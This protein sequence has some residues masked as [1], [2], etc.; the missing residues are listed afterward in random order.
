MLVLKFIFFHFDSGLV[1]KSPLLFCFDTVDSWQPDTGEAT[2]IAATTGTGDEGGPTLAE[3]VLRRRRTTSAPARS[4]ND[5]R[6]ITYM[7]NKVIELEAKLKHDEL[8]LEP[9]KSR[10]VAEFSQCEEFLL[11]EIDLI[12]RHMQGW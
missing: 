5:Q 7:R 2:P 9:S 11:G 4:A 12:S 1:K 10:P 3:L 6:L 8:E